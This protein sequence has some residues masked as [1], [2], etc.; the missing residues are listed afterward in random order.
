MTANNDY[1]NNEKE[2][3]EFK[4]KRPSFPPKIDPKE[5]VAKLINHK[6][7]SP[8]VPNEFFIYRAALVKELK[9]NNC[10]VKMTKVSTIASESWNLETLKVKTEYRK[11]A[12]ETENL[13][14]KALSSLDYNDLV[15]LNLN[16]GLFLNDINNNNLQKGEI[17]IT[18]GLGLD[19]F[20]SPFLSYNHND[21]ILNPFNF[22][23]NDINNELI[24]SNS[25]PP[26]P[27]LSL[28]SYS[29]SNGFSTQSSPIIWSMPESPLVSIPNPTP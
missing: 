3:I 10:R 18:Q 1:N 21:P 6:S 12:R 26:S 14:N 11:L 16:L 4:I 13:Y 2:T 25:L 7:K 24:N 15:D 20:G 19:I 8:K 5:L 9:E 28:I 29:T 27:T 17:S 22:V 23:S